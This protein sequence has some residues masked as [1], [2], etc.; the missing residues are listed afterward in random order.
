VLE[1]ANGL[2][3]LEICRR[4]RS[5]IDVVLTDMVMPAMTG[6]ELI[7]RLTQEGIQL[8]IV[9]MSGYA[10]GSVLQNHTLS[11]TIAYLPKPFSPSALLEKI[12]GAVPEPP[13][14]AIR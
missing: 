13:A 12:A 10:E 3:A 9:C 5:E 8:P 7:E 1:A 6:T 2:D 4:Q 14:V 11:A